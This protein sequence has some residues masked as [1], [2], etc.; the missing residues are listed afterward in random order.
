M[1]KLAVVAAVGVMAIMGCS[2]GETER[3]PQGFVRGDAKVLSVAHPKDWQRG[4][5][6]DI[7]L[8]MQAPEQTAF[9]S[10]L[11]DVARGGDSARL[12][13]T[14]EIGPM[15]NAKDYG[16]GGG[17][18]RQLDQGALTVGQRPRSPVGRRGRSG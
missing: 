12:E 4:P 16:P 2:S 3:T 9:L 5:E 18:H 1:R 14:I 8:S 17:R 11:S 15:M 13:T 10:V 6:S 7:A